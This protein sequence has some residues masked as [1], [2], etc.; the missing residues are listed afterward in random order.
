M[1]AAMPTEPESI[2]LS[3]L[4]RRAVELC[5][6]EGQDADLGDFEAEFEDADEPVTSIENL[7]E[8]LAIAEE[9]VDYDIDSPAISMAVATVL[10][11]AHRRD[12]VDDEPTDVL[13]LA[14][15]AEWK[16]D[17]PEAVVDWLAARGISLH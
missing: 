7:E 12:E 8:R 13:R 17:P 14:V 2:T 11:L 16:G 10:Y 9:G 1:V 3:E 6:P 15:R 5:D 4:V